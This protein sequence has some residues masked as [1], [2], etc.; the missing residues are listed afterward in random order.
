VIK[1][2]LLSHIPESTLNQGKY[3]KL[4]SYTTLRICTQAT[5]VTS[6]FSNKKNTSITWL[7]I[8]CKIKYT[9]IIYNWSKW[10]AGFGF[11]KK[12]KK[13]SV[14]INML[15][16]STCNICKELNFQRPW[17]KHGH[18][19]KMGSVQAWKVLQWASPQLGIACLLDLLFGSRSVIFHHTIWCHI[20]EEGGT[21]YSSLLNV[22]CLH[23]SLSLFLLVLM[24][25]SH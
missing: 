11:E 15:K 20:P 12:K 21:L 22:I 7:L 18:E 23:I 16:Q 2:V 19:S 10:N 24:E 3:T 1:F 14:A 8:F 4:W 13:F 5:S 25:C 17:L 6:V 9:T